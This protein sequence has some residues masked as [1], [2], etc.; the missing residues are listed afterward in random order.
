MDEAL[1]KDFE[2]VVN[3]ESI[4]WNSGLVCKLCPNIAERRASNAAFNRFV[5]N[6]RDEKGLFGNFL[7]ASLG[8][9]L[10]INE[11]SDAEFFLGVAREVGNKDIYRQI[12]RSITKMTVEDCLE[13]LY[14]MSECDEDLQDDAEFIG[15]NIGSVGS[16]QLK[17]L[18]PK[19]LKKVVDEAMEKDF[20]FVVNGEPVFWNSSLV[21]RLCPIIGER[22]ARDAAFNRFVVNTRDEKGLF[23]KFLSVSL[24]EK[25]EISDAS[26]AEFFRGVGR[27]VGN[28]EIYRQSRR[29]ITKMTVEDCLQRLYAMSECDED[30]QDDIDFIIANIG[31]VGNDQLK[32]LDPETLRKVLGSG[33]LAFPTEDDLYQF[34]A[35]IVSENSDNRDA[36]FRLFSVVRFERLSPERMKD[37]CSRCGESL[38]AMDS[39]MWEHLSTR[40]CCDV[41]APKLRSRHKQR[42]AAQSEDE[43]YEYDFFEDNYDEKKPTYPRVIMI[44][45]DD[46][47][48]SI[49]LY[50]LRLGSCI[51]TV[52]TVGFNCE[53]IECNGLSL[54]IWD[55]GGRA[56]LRPLW[57]QFTLED[58]VGV[59]F[60]VNAADRSRFDEARNALHRYLRE[61]ELA[62]IPLLVYANKQDLAD[63][64]PPEE[65]SVALELDKLTDRP[66]KCV[67]STGRGPSYETL[68]AGIEWLVDEVLKDDH[69]SKCVDAPVSKQPVSRPCLEDQEP[70]IPARSLPDGD[71]DDDATKVVMIGLDGAGKTTALYHMKL[72]EMVKTIPTD[73]FVTEDLKCNGRTVHVWDL[74]GK[75]RLR[76]LWQRYMERTSAI[77]YVV[78]AAEK[79]RFDEARDE[80]HK[81]IETHVPAGVPLLVYANKQDCEG[82][83]QPEELSVALN[84]GKLTNRPWKC[85]GNSNKQS[86]CVDLWKGLEWVLSEAQ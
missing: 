53:T 23:G 17:K 32:K 83:V 24:G 77:I 74:A 16:D 57:R 1:E 64:A 18:D 73:G 72:G 56:V 81:F 26:D 82:A 50:G 42:Y 2:F 43:G 39:V 65:V 3:G 36:Y 15:A 37:F 55:L 9:K 44:G 34:I 5:V 59:I 79:S 71:D 45:L 70:E 40:L 10:Q 78:D 63:A 8:E 20:E 31:S 47:G 51:T 54:T 52:P 69:E 22:R 49:C 7:S 13:R 75:D 85:V 27:E 86:P 28:K 25:L 58:T 60:V 35:E 46:A 76:S 11:P 80:L 14:A 4:F 62:D 21:C 38:P 30:L 48:K 33:A 19:I 61:N 29:F 6:T 41:D 66:W 68:W 84:L 12:R 67:K